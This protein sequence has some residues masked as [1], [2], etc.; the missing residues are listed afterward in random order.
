MNKRLIDGDKLLHRAKEITES[1]IA[2]SMELWE[3]INEIENGAFDVPSDQGET[4]RLRAALGSIQ[5][6]EWERTHELNGLEVWTTKRINPVKIA[7]E[8]LYLHAED[9]GIQKVEKVGVCNVKRHFDGLQ[10]LLDDVNWNGDKQA[11]R[12]EQKTIRYTLYMLGI[13]I[14]GISMEVDKGHD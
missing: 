10:G 13:T 5:W 3:L 9:T 1:P 6:G 4:A 11:I 12:D 7:Q 2:P 8:A 14:P